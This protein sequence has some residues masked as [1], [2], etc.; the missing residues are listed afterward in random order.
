MP[1]MP[2]RAYRRTAFFYPDIAWS[3]CINR[4]LFP[5]I[6]AVL[7]SGLRLIENPVA[8][9]H[10]RMHPY[11]HKDILWF[12]QAR[13]L[14]YISW[15]QAVFW[16]QVVSLRRPLVRAEGSWLAIQL[17]VLGSVLK[18]ECLLCTLRSE[19]PRRHDNITKII[20]FHYCLLCVINNLMHVQ[21]EWS[22]L[23]I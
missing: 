17:C 2:Q 7:K 6:P 20:I 22:G 13:A 11:P 16:S 1:R 3:L 18:Y 8:L 15:D 14:F 4:R 23:E 19:I 21:L 5:I 12:S 9:I 10:F